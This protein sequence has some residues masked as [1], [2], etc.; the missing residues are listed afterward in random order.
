MSPLPPC[1]LASSF[2]SSRWV[3]SPPA[4]R[5]DRDVFVVSCRNMIQKGMVV[6]CR[7]QD[8]AEKAGALETNSKVLTSGETLHRKISRRETL[9]LSTSGTS[10]LLAFLN[11]SGTR[12]DYLG[13][14]TNP[15]SLALCPLSPPCISTSEEANDPA[16]YIPPWTYNP[17]DGRGR[18]NPASKEKAMAELLETIQSTK[19]DNFTPRIVEKTDDYVYVEYSSP[20]LGFVDDVEFWF[21]PGK[22]S[23]VEYRSASRSGQIDFGFNRKRIKALRKALERYGWESVGF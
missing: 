2:T 1:V 16:H 6:C 18:K 9:L 8:L 21:P 23:L 22:R 19:P 10:L 11:F 13:V 4:V 7:R 15:P 17:E 20:F 12:P 5:L 14:Q 3:F